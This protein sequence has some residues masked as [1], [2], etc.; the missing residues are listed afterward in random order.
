MSIK[1]LKSNYYKYPVKYHEL[2]E[3]Q[4]ETIINA[5]LRIM[6]NIGLVIKHERARTMLKDAGCTVDG[7]T[8]RF[9]K[10]LVIDC[11]NS[12]AKELVLYDRN[13]NK[14]LQVSG[15]NTYF[16]LGP[17]NPFT[18]DFETGERRKACR[19]DVKNSVLVADACPNID[20]MMGL[21]QVQ[22]CD[23][24]ISDVV[25]MREMLENTTKPIVGWGVNVQGLKDQVEMCAAVAGG[26]DK[27]REKP[28]L[29]LFPGCPVSPLIIA[30]N[31]FEKIEYSIQEGFS[32]V[33]SSGAQLGTVT[34]V[35]IAGAFSL[36]LAE[37]F[38]GIVLAQLI[39]KGSCVVC[40]VVVLTVDM[41]TT[42]AAYGSP[43]HCIGEAMSADI[44]HYLDLPMWQTAGVTDSKSADEQSAI[45]CSMGALINT[46]SGGHMVHDVG[47]LD[48]AMS[49]SLD[50]IVLN[51]EII[52]YAKRVARG[53][54]IDEET[55]AYDVIEEVGPGGEFLTSE[56]TAENFREEFWFPK[57]IDRSRYTIWEEKKEDMR[58]RV[59]NRTAKILA[60]HK[61]EPLS[62]EVLRK[63]DA[64]LEEAQKRLS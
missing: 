22:D 9:P 17:T 52:G 25:E 46:I 54:T 5:S 47:F 33:W 28:F 12:A 11:I 7:E 30:E 36:N 39:K 50:Q 44:F 23:I 18:N 48:G 29:S 56:H 38:A 43:E 63:L 57:L 60:E 32:I 8:V 14:A 16:G 31:E 51:D 6:E 58:T 27:L 40:G 53:I 49:A 2:T 59:H 61:P 21:A 4:C 62:E 64:I 42:Q 37:I 41:G 10:E 3:E 20:F 55:L 34:P 1:G 45:E 26:I 24:R 15:T 19:K 13:G 35:T